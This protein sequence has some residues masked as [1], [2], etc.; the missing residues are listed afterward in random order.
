MQIGQESKGADGAQYATYVIHGLVACPNFTL[1]M[2][3]ERSLLCGQVMCA[4]SLLDHQRNQ[5]SLKRLT[6]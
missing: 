1:A 6:R 3:G 5:M 2:S 4:V